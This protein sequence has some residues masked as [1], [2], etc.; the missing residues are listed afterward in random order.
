ML[1]SEPQ[2]SLV[3]HLLSNLCTGLKLRNVSIVRHFLLLAKS[4][5]PPNLHIC[6]VFHHP[7]LLS[8]TPGSKPTFSINP[9]Y[10]NLPQR[11]DRFDEFFY[12]FWTLLI[13]FVVCSLIY[14]F[15][16]SI[17]QLHVKSSHSSFLFMD[18][19]MHNV[20]K[21]TLYKYRPYK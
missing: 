1:S 5:P 17:L 21:P 13:V 18:K 16:F 19:S 8:S 12:Y 20:N 11:L 14:K 6:T 7:S 10:H 9:F 2:Y 15:L 3:S 4:L